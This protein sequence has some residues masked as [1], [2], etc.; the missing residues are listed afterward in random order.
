VFGKINAMNNV[1]VVARFGIRSVPALL[2]FK[3][4]KWMCQ[5]SGFKNLQEIQNSIE[6]YLL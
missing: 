4:G 6:N 2:Y 3:G 1:E 5:E